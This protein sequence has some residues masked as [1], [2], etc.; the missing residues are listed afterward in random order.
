MLIF[1]ANA[2]AC[3]DNDANNNQT[4]NNQTQNKTEKKD[5]VSTEP[6]I[7]VN[8]PFVFDDLE[9]TISSDISF[10]KVDNRYSDHNGQDVVKVPITVK[11]LKNETHNL[12]MFYYDVYG[13]LGTEI[14]TVGSYFDE[15]INTAGGLRNGASYTKYMYFLYDG[16]G[17][18]YIEF[19]DWSEKLELKLT[20]NKT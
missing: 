1:L 8:K 15:D 20:V 11:N 7:V 13:S 5:D 16:D 6:E 10:D 18:Y 3:T 2:T 9:I 14:E 19:D 17:D 4:N 12:N